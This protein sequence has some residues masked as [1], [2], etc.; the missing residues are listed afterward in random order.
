MKEKSHVPVFYHNLSYSDETKMLRR[1]FSESN[2]SSEWSAPLLLPET[3]AIRSPDI[4]WELLLMKEIKINY[5][6]II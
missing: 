6:N 5:K 1:I 3:E 4:V 2:A